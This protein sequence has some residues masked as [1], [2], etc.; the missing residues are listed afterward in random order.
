MNMVTNHLT[1]IAMKSMFDFAKADNLVMTP[2]SKKRIPLKESDALKANGSLKDYVVKDGDTYYKEVK[3]SDEARKK[4]I[5]REKGRLI[6]K[7]KKTLNFL[8]TLVLL[9]SIWRTIK[10]CMI[11]Y[12]FYP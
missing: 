9:S 1:K 4:W 10:K 6:D 5:K 2:P 11:N 12:D 8:F 7:Q 3:M